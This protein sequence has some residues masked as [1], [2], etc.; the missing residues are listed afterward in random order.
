[1]QPLAIVPLSAAKQLAKKQLRAIES[2]IMRGIAAGYRLR[3]SG[4]TWKS[5][6]QV[7]EG[8]PDSG[9]RRDAQEVAIRNERG[10]RRR[11]GFYFI[12]AGKSDQRRTYRFGTAE[13]PNS[14]IVV[15]LQLREHSPVDR[16]TG[17]SC[18]PASTA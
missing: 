9:E 15:V 1:M 6:A 8:R 11:D 5:Q 17:R 16:A 12:A 3:P 14:G 13:E 7:C 4:P 18:A 10:K 2:P